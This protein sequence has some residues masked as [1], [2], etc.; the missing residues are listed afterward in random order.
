MSPCC[1]CGV[2][3]VY[4]AHIWACT[5]MRHS[6]LCLRAL[7]S[8]FALFKE[9]ESCLCEGTSNAAV[10]KTKNISIWS[11]VSSSCWNYVCSSCLRWIDELALTFRQINQQEGYKENWAF[12]R[13]FYSTF[14]TTRHFLRSAAEKEA[15]IWMYS[16][17]GLVKLIQKMFN[18]H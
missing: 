3:Q 4:T 15:I 18:C 5:K 2:I 14:C 12:C 9:K 7:G 13:R 11:A 10:H 17:L 1:S 6:C 16:C 8:Y